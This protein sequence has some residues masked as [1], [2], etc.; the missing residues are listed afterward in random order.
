VKHYVFTSRIYCIIG[1]PTVSS[2]FLG[3][4]LVAYNMMVPSPAK[5][6]TPF[7]IPL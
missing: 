6:I 7:I 1:L 5:G 3:M 4:A 2:V